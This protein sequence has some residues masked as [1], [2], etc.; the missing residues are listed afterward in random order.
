VQVG[1]A[2]LVQAGALFL[3]AGRLRWGAGWA[4]V[5]HYLGVLGVNAAILLRRDPE[6][7]AERG[8]SFGRA[9]G[10][11]RVLAPF[12]I[13]ST[14]G[15]LVVSGLDGRFRWTGR[16][17]WERPLEP[18]KLTP[19][20]VRRGF[21]S[22]LVALGTPAN[23]PKPCGRFPGRPKGRLSGQ[24]TRYPVLKKAA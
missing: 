14:L 7:I 6:L 15:D 24:A 16:L 2:L 13:V 1:V 10:V 8:R 22:L 21:P 20:R 5:G 23:A 19:Y 18:D 3:T 17:P 12:L 11:D 9:K 4:F